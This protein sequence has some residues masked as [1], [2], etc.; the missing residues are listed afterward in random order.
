MRYSVKAKTEQHKSNSKGQTTIPPVLICVSAHWEAEH[1]EQVRY[2]SNG[3]DAPI[4]LSPCRRL[5]CL[6]WSSWFLL[7][8]INEKE[9]ENKPISSVDT[10]DSER[11]QAMG[12]SRQFIRCI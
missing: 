9:N 12:E 8:V 11:T 10:N 5:S 7:L 4:H 1:M 2:K 3:L 6:V